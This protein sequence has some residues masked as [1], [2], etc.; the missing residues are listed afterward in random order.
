MPAAGAGNA[1][2]FIGLY[3]GAG[4]FGNTHQNADGIA[5]ARIPAVYAWL[6]YLSGLFGLDFTDDIH[7]P[8]TF[9]SSKTVRALVTDPSASRASGGRRCGK[10]GFTILYLVVVGLFRLAGHIHHTSIKM[11]SLSRPFFLPLSKV[12]TAVLRVSFSDSSLPPGLD[13]GHGCPIRQHGLG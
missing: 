7:G 3:A 8:Q 10:S 2:A 11:S 9:L 4:A 12:R 1:H 13:R 6:R 5:R